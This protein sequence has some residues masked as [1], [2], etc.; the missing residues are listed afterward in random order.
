MLFINNL[1]NTIHIKTPAHLT[2]PHK[3]HL[4]LG[5]TGGKEILDEFFLF[6]DQ[7]SVMMFQTNKKNKNG[8]YPSFFF[9]YGNFKNM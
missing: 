2:N 3:T 9:K 6:F 8:G 7:W 4:K 1:Y 5:S